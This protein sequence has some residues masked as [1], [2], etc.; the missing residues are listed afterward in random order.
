MKTRCTSVLILLFSLLLSATI[1]AQSRIPSDPNLWLVSSSTTGSGDRDQINVAFFEIPDTV[2]STLYFAINNPGITGADPDQN[3]A[4]GFATDYTL[5]GGSGTLSNSQSKQTEY[6]TGGSP[7]IGTQLG[8][9][10]YTDTTS[11]WVYFPGVSP[12]QGEH[13]GN[14]Y[15][16]K[17][18]IE[19][20]G[21][22][23]KNAYQLD[24]SLNNSGTPTQVSDVNS[25]CYAWNINMR[26]NGD[27]FNIYPFV[28]DGS[29]GNYFVVSTFDYD[30]DAAGDI[31]VTVYDKDSTNLGAAAVSN[32]D[33][34]SNTGFLIGAGEDQ[35]TW[36]VDTY[37]GTTIA[38]MNASEF[39]AWLSSDNLFLASGVDS[40]TDPNAFPET[41]GNAIEVLRSYA[42]SVTVGTADHIA[43]TVEDGVASSDSTDIETITLQIVDDTGTPQP[44][45][46][47]IWVELSG[48]AFLQEINDVASAAFLA[49][50]GGTWPGGDAQKGYLDTDSQGMVTIG[51]SNGTTE[52]VT[53]SVI[54]DGTASTSGDDDT[55]E[56]TAPG[57]HD[58]AVVDFQA[59]P[60]PTMSSAQNTSFVEANVAAVS[61]PDITITEVGATSILGTQ[62]ILIRIPLAYQANA[63]FSA[64]V[65][66]LD[67]SSTVS[68]SAISFDD[69]DHLRINPTSDFS[70]GDFM[71][72]QGLEIEIGAVE[73]V[74]QLEMSYDSG[75]TYDVIDDKIISILDSNTTY[76]WTGG[77]S[78]D[79]SDQLNWDI[80]DGTPGDDGFPVA[81]E[82]VIIPDVTTQP[83][84]DVAA[85]LNNLTI[86]GSATMDLSGQ[87]LTVG[88]TF[89][90][91]GT[92]YLQGGETVSGLSDFDSGTT[93]YTGA[94]G[95]NNYPSPLAA[96]Y[97]YYNLI[98]N[99]ATL[100]DTWNLDADLNVYGDLTVSGGTLSQGT[101]DLYLSGDAD[102]TS[103]NFTKNGANTVIFDGSLT[104]TLTS[105]G[106]DLGNVQIN[107]AAS[108][109]TSDASNFDD[110]TISGTFT[111]GAAI[112]A[113]GDWTNTGSFFSG[114]F[115]TTF[116]G[117]G[118][119]TINTGGVAV[120]QDF[121][122]LI[123]NG[124]GDFTF[125]TA[126]DADGSV[127][128][129]DSSGI[130]FAGLTTPTV[131]LSDTTGTIQFGGNTTISAGL[132]ANANPYEVTF[133]G[134]LIS[135]AGDSTFNN[136]GGVTLG[137]TV[138]DVLTFSGGLDTS[139][140]VT[141]AAG[142]VSTTDAQMDIGAITL[143][144]DLTLDT[145][146]AAASLMNL[147][148]V[149]S[150]GNALI[151]DSGAD[152]AADITV[153]GFTGG[154]DLT[155][156]DSGGATFSGAVTAGA[157]TLSDTTGIITF[158]GD[159]T[160]ASLTTASTYDL[161]IGGALNSITA[162][163]IFSNTGSLTLGNDAGDSLT[164]DGGFTATAPNPISL[165]GSISSSDDAVT[166]DPA[167]LSA[168]VSITTGGGDLSV[169]TLDNAQDLTL[170]TT[171]GAGGGSI[172]FNGILG[173]VTPFSALTIDGKGAVALPETHVN[174][175]L[176]V[177][178]DGTITDTSTLTI[179]GT[180]SLNVGVAA[181]ILLDDNGDAVYTNTFGTISLAC[182]DNAAIYEA[183]P[184]ALDTSSVV[185]DLVLDSTSAGAGLGDITQIGA[186]SVQGNI[187][188][189]ADASAITLD[190]D[191]NAFNGILTITNTG[192]ASEVHDTDDII[193]GTI[194]TGTLVIDAAN[195]A[196]GNITQ[197][198]V[199]IVTSGVSTFDV[200]VGPSDILLVNDNNISGL[201]TVGTNLNVQD[202]TIRNINAAAAVPVLPATL[203]DLTLEFTTA[204]IT[205]PAVDL[206]GDLVVLAGGDILQSGT[207]EV[208]LTSNL[209]AVGDI[210]LSTVTNDFTG[211]VTVPSGTAVSLADTNGIILGAVT[212]GTLIVDAANGFVGNI[213]QS[214]VTIITSGAST[215]DVGTGIVASDILLGNDNDISGLITVGTAGVIRDLTIRN[216]NAAATVPVLPATLRNLTLQFTT[217]SITI[218]AINI[219]GDLVILAGG[220]ILQSG[221]I[222]V[223]LTS[224]LTAGNNITLT[225]ATNDF[226]GAVTVP[227]GV[228]VTLVDDT[229]I[230]LD[231]I[232]TTG[233]FDVTA[234][235][236]TVAGAIAADSLD[237]D[238]S[239]A[240]GTITDTTGSILVTNAA[241]LAAQASDDILLD[242]ANDFQGAV[243][244][245]SGQNI[246]LN[247]INA[248]TVSSAVAS[249][250]LTLIADGLT[251][252]T[253]ATAG[254]AGAGDGDITI[255][256]TTG[257]I[258]AAYLSA[259]ADT[260]TLTAA[261]GVTELTPD[262]GDDI[263]SA[264][265][266]VVS[267][268]GFG[269]ADAF[270]TAVST[271]DIQNAT[272]GAINLVDSSGA[273]D[274]Q[275]IVQ[276]TTGAVD[277]SENGNLTVSANG[278]IVNGAGNV[279]LTALGAGNDITVTADISSGSGILTLSAADLV[280]LQADL[281]TAAGNL[282]ITGS[283]TG[284]EINAAGV[285]LSTGAAGG[286]IVLTGNIDSAGGQPLSL[287]AGTGNL[288]VNNDVGSSSSLGVLT[289]SSV[290]DASFAG[291]ISAS[292]LVQTAGTGTSVFNGAISTTG[293][294]DLNGAAFTFNNSVTTGGGG[295]VT[296]TNSGLITI[297]AG[298]DFSP[299]GAFTVDGNGNI[300]LAADISTTADNIIFDGT[301]VLTIADNG[302]GTDVTID[303][304]GGNI[305]FDGDV[306]GAGLLNL[307]ALTGTIDFNS[308]VG[309]TLALSGL[310][311]PSSADV[312]FTDTVD[313]DGENLDIDSVL[314]S[315]NNAVSSTNGGTVTLTNS[316]A[317]AILAAAD[318]N[319]DG[320]FTV[321]GN[322]A[323]SLA[324]D[325]ATTADNILFD[326]TG[327]LTVVNTG[328]SPDVTIN[329]TGG[330]VQFDGTVSGA[331][332]LSVASGA[333]IIDFNSTVG[334]GPVLS[335]LIIPSSAAVSF[336]NTV[337][338]DAENLDI[339][340]VD[341]TFQNALTTANSGTV[342]IANTGDLTIPVTAPFT[343]EGLFSQ[344]GA[345]DVY[346]DA[347][348]TTTNDD[349]SFVGPFLM[350]Q[351]I[352]LSTGAGGI[353]NITFGASSTVDGNLASPDLI[354]IAGTGNITLSGAV[355]TVS[356]NLNDL[357]AS[358]ADIS[359]DS[360]GDGGGDGIDGILTL[361][362]S[363]IVTLTGSNY[364]TAG[365]QNYNTTNGTIWSHSGSG[366]FQSGGTITFDDVYL[367]YSSLVTITLLTDVNTALFVF[368]DGTLDLNGRTITTSENGGGILWSSA[369]ALIRMTPTG[370]ELMTISGL[371]ILIEH[372]FFMIRKP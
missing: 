108:L 296:L 352:T 25:F 23:Y 365:N 210:T 236:I 102:F 134:A 206:S 232:T 154:G 257:D 341:V 354:L 180:V 324:G 107:A 251:T 194:S 192:G 185:G 226:T 342:T 304:A 166:L 357:T 100:N 105:A 85:I 288:T 42:S 228:A 32:S 366:S 160:A 191:T 344:T 14:K 78:T 79:W 281:T 40:G 290:A 318:F 13:I 323:V 202:L 120:N 237:F 10:S 164:F 6:V 52:S 337:A 195:G 200:A 94:A 146:T 165:A 55:S 138:T 133:T 301:G 292:S 140:G 314:I 371:I 283:T 149:T 216:I 212:A 331:G 262:V 312:T 169:N 54:A 19:V 327:A 268:T 297:A 277:I 34:S 124:T 267:T 361:T 109:V 128:V 300:S 110:V 136:T 307:T 356:S 125:S 57:T 188:L 82:N 156:T 1:G 359:L 26:N 71:L 193:L 273:L 203:R 12:S 114:G 83:V 355:G 225:T 53:I 36:Q 372:L 33:A 41:Y 198:G 150:G 137:D 64:T 132:T 184:I 348:I 58:T 37:E 204:D 233:L 263:L 81:G 260:I 207:V 265:L 70:D 358:G 152:A 20:A 176:S 253:T 252:V 143:T 330:N 326:G 269:S 259:A 370:T 328:G 338:I 11:G 50:I 309:S 248:L 369:A 91:D 163:V 291:S 364:R 99:D 196:A 87:N 145:G 303:S 98:F 121:D 141:T 282:N 189:S 171:G 285:A 43:M 62:D 319:L 5:I 209:T 247:D 240:A 213:T 69:T 275:R 46:E 112:N 28:P 24:V 157:L 322:G 241:V 295:T 353:G 286:N 351:N 29:A 178:A 272:S 350:A 333:G 320:S 51:I 199:T 242:G 363:N 227:A 158:S 104:Q 16:F 2:T 175:A 63:D 190:V 153:A 238:A 21:G 317:L 96:G 305:Q 139:A 201:I 334:A 211:A 321:D 38:Y 231:A 332:L 66:S 261:G 116:D 222:L 4:G 336:T 278:I 367:D 258:D 72:L 49:G 215:F 39:Y 340:A 30:Q 254:G 172:T 93:E 360:I 244:V 205:L 170:D 61:L 235:S 335:G 276:T 313:I 155:L 345:G 346:C 255:T 249:A 151:L 148:T 279:D 89:N 294:V 67:V 27:T 167:T 103:G 84:M 246:T 217:A 8:Q 17:V 329:S 44:Y 243:T 311:I 214:G 3:L 270:E 343:L 325:I 129:T 223:A 80:G 92:I 45:V 111:S 31:T 347:N 174:G 183:A 271:V 117:T 306:S 65:P 76:V 208:A 298:A 161:L 299:D 168:A 219:T 144:A 264:D 315:F 22:G 7:Y 349:I 119:Q 310:I 162:A 9:L 339:S 147:G 234:D 197:D 182:L 130:V 362:S 113:G 95:I 56:W 75:G 229:G 101:N 47:R 60:I 68:A 284:I 308:T 135:V 287:T 88:G 159:L 115:S 293:V 77:T 302:P 90:N 106:E 274:I 173:G 126:L 18:V 127:T 316:G 218:P 368:Y 181:V 256:T 280:N 131:I 97:D 86:A 230:I 177:T 142:S 73:C 221:A 250:D 74:F 266:V 35:G 239:A 179:T 245:S 220:D 186:V 187:S 224:S 48:S 289:V 59:N 122:D 118:S 123:I 15:Y